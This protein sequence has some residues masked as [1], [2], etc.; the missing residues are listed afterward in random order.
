[1]DAK[2]EIVNGTPNNDTLNTYNL[3]EIINGL[4]GGDAINAKGGNDVINGGDGI[5][6]LTGGPGADAFL[7]DLKPKKK[8]NFDHITEFLPGTDEIRL[9]LDI[10]TKLKPGDLK[11]KAFFAKKKADEG[12]DGND[13]IVV[14]KKSGE[15]WYDKDGEGGAKAKLF[16]ILDGSPDD[17]SHTDF[18]VVA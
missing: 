11:K 12:H 9:D 8:S 17:I 13:R 10:F 15:C 5:D 6:T 4:A 16:A 14:D 2:V 7:F 3:S 18:V 1:M